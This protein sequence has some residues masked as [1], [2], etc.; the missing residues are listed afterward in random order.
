[1]QYA[2]AWG[3]GIAPWFRKLS[4][5]PVYF[6]AVSFMPYVYGSQNMLDSQELLNES[7]RAQYINEEKKCTSVWIETDNVLKLTFL[8]TQ[9]YPQWKGTL[10]K[11]TRVIITMMVPC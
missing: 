10:E 5:F 11:S 7:N 3:Q 2:I 9:A 1:M 8:C 6:L 4:S